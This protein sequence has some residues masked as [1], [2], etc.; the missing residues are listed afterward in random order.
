[1]KT[2]FLIATAIAAL[3]AGTGVSAAQG[4]NK[5]SHHGGAAPAARPAAPAAP[6][7]R[8]AAPA[9]R[10]QVQMQRPSGGQLHVNESRGPSLNR[11]ATPNREHGNRVGQTERMT[12]GRAEVDTRGRANIERNDRTTRG[13]AELNTRGRVDSRRTREELRS[14]E[15]NRQ[16]LERG[17]REQDRRGSASETRHEKASLSSEQ[18]TRIRETIL[19][20]R[21]T[22][23]IARPDFDIRVGYRIPRNRIHFRLLPL[24]TTIVDLEPEWQ[25]YLYFLVGDEVVVVDP[26]TYEIVA[27]LPA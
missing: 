10:P 22:P 25:G 5:D 21:D 19:S 11:Q 27:V 8:P 24:P 2:K 1:M 3:L 23:R 13:R 14:G 4:N 17:R 16:V 20:R 9:A 26:D 15:R 18:R 7:A 6:A 12:R